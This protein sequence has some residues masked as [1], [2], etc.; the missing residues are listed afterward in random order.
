MSVNSRGEGFDFVVRFLTS[1]F[2]AIGIPKDNR[3][4]I[5]HPILRQ[6]LM[7]HKSTVHRS[8]SL[9]FP[10]HVVTPCGHGIPHP[11]HDAAR[12]LTWS[13]WTARNC[14]A[15]WS[16]SSLRSLP[17]S[18]ICPTKA[19]A[20]LS[21]LP[22]SGSSVG[23]GLTRRSSRRIT[24]ACCLCGCSCFYLG[25]PGLYLCLGW[26]RRENPGPKQQAPCIKWIDVVD[27]CFVFILLLV[28]LVAICCGRVHIFL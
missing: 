23:S 7:L 1:K 17:A 24:L 4:G 19:E 8:L 18:T 5:L 22:Y 3:W 28:I 16:G 21:T 6:H 15:P 2:P 12:R 20:Q 27:W 11:A 10:S 9:H 14:S 26:R 25:T 13:S